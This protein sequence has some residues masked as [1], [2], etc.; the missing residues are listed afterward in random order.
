M[1]YKVFTNNGEFYLGYLFNITDTESIRSYLK[2]DLGNQL[3]DG[4]ISQE[5][6]DEKLSNII[7]LTKEELEKDLDDYDLFVTSS[8]TAFP[9]SELDDSQLSCV[10]N[11]P[12]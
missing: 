6:Y 10:G 11:A 9:E 8:A 1:Y 5:E 7:S 4:N 3:D 2:W 12:W